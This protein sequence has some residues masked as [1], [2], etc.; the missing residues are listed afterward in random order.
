MTNEKPQARLDAEPGQELDDE[1]LD[2][3]AGGA[4]AEGTTSTAKGVVS[5]DLSVS[6]AVVPGQNILDAA[7]GGA[8]GGSTAGE[9]M[10]RSLEEQN[11]VSTTVDGAGTTRGTTGKG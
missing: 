6:G 10:I 11:M 8:L 3:I 4:T 2:E 1:T 7:I 5:V 9:G